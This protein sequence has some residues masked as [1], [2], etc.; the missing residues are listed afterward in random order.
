MI[1]QQIFK[2]F[3]KLETLEII[4]SKIDLVEKNLFAKASKIKNLELSYNGFY[5][6]PYDIFY[7]L[8]KIEIISLRGNHLEYI[9][10]LLFRKNP[11]LM[12]LNLQDNN[13]NYVDHRIL[14]QPK[15]KFLLLENNVCD[16][17]NHIIDHHRDEL[18]KQKLKVCFN[19]F[20]TTGVIYKILLKR[21]LQSQN[22]KEVALNFT[23][24]FQILHDK[25]DDSVKIFEKK[26]FQQTMDNLNK[27]LNLK[28]FLEEKQR[29]SSYEKSYKEIRNY[30]QMRLKNF[31]ILYTNLLK[32]TSEARNLVIKTKIP[33]NILLLLEILE[34]QEN[35]VLFE[36]KFIKNKTD[37]I[38][39]FNHFKNCPEIT[40]IS[41][42]TK[43]ILEFEDARLFLSVV[44]GILIL[45]IFLNIIVMYVLLIYFKIGAAP[46][47]IWC[48]FINIR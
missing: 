28:H 6:L 35:F 27:S 41:N 16:S 10:R 30:H 2:S 13:I 37:V 46:T 14:I 25:L 4:Y 9:D 1:P 5:T 36:E 12:T 44:L 26:D 24:E 32:N 22:N 20:R 11:K 18:M 19:N 31:T 8:L 23:S 15:L 43:V 47:R 29:N 39:N 42:N 34:F 21:E 7:S 45:L 38:F 40:N 33:E 17:K 3:P 48:C